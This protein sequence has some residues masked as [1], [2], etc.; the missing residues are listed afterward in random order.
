MSPKILLRA[1]FVVLI[2]VILVIAYFYAEALI[3]PSYYWGRGAQPW[4][5]YFFGF[6]VRVVMPVLIGDGVIIILAAMMRHSS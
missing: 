2:A 4:Y 1:G 6:P 3:N 5:V